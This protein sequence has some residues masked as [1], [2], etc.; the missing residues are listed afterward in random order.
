MKKGTG[1]EKRE[2]IKEEYRTCLHLTGA[3]QHYFNDR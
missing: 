1:E 2:E 3:I